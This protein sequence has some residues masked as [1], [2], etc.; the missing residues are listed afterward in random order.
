V[1][2]DLAVAV[3]VAAT[4]LHLGFQ[5]TVTLVVYPALARVP[6]DGWVVAHDRHSRAIAPL[7]AVVYG[8]LVV[9]AVAVLTTDVTPASLAA[10]VA[11]AVA[12]LTTAGLAAPLHGRLGQ[13]DQRLVVRLLAADRV[14][15]G[16]AVVAALAAAVATVAR[17]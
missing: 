6:V 1:T 15:L 12:V 3:L 11:A 10:V 16:A 13:R 7:V 4:W 9:G 2:A 14:R 8:A 5:A 17:W